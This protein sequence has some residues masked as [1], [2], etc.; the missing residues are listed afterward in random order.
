MMKPEMVDGRI[1]DVGYFNDI[2]GFLWVMKGVFVAKY[3]GCVSSVSIDWMW[4]P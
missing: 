3:L 1:P 4:M 2:S